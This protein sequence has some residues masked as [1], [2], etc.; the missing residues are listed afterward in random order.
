MGGTYF[1]Q[2][3]IVVNKDMKVEESHRI[4]N[5]ARECIYK[6]FDLI[7]EIIVHVD[8]SS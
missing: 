5:E 6:E 4:V 1:L 7:G 3:H 2:V 8:P